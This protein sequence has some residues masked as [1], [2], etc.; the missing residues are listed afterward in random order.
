MAAFMDRYFP[1]AESIPSVPSDFAER[2]ERYTGEF[3]ANRR[4]YTTFL[5]IGAL[6]GETV[7]V[8]DRGTLKVLRTDWVEV[9]PMVFQEEYGSR[10]LIFREN[11][12][13]KITH[14]FVSNNPILAWERA[15]PGEGTA[16]HT[17]LFVTAMVLVVLTLVSPLLGWALRRWYGVPAGE[18][19]RIP[20]AARWTLWSA[21]LLFGLSVIALLLV[22]E[23]PGVIGSRSP[24]L[25]FVFL[26]P[27]L[28]VLPTVASLV[29]ATLL[30]TKRGGRPTVRVAYSVVT[31]SFCLLLW[32]MSVWNVLGW[33]Y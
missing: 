33:Q 11:D 27:V 6:G 26:V 18:L 15:Q 22:A 19:E 8:T 25:G 5:K 13:G 3:R 2:G 30:W 14:F 9:E 10:R 31:L 29:F 16:L 23:N 20:K 21:A 17:S 24:I 4:A 32:Q 28:A 12:A 1:V 7:R